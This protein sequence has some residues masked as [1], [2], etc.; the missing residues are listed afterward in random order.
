[1]NVVGKRKKKQAD[2]PKKHKPSYKDTK[3]LSKL[4]K[5]YDIAFDRYK[6]EWFI[7]RDKLDDYRNDIEDVTIATLQN[8]LQVTKQAHYNY[9]ISQDNLLDCDD[10]DMDDDRIRDMREENTDA[11]KN[12]RLFENTVLEV[13]ADAERRH[14]EMSKTMWY[15]FVIY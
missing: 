2:K 6:D 12:L 13:A 8:A 15:I 14:A 4:W 10:L 1:M 3:L 9:Q 5:K 7:L 11:T